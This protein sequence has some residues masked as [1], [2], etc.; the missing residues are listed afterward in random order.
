MLCSGKNQMGKIAFFPNYVGMGQRKRGLPNFQND[1]T[2]EQWGSMKLNATQDSYLGSY[3]IDI[4]TYG[5]VCGSI[6]TAAYCGWSRRWGWS[7]AVSE[8]RQC[9]VW[10]I[11]P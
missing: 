7:C 6:A 11:I 10:I 5:T 4:I 8:K 9:L 2:T 1:G 3:S